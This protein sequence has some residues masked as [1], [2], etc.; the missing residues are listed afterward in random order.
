MALTPRYKNFTESISDFNRMLDGMNKFQPLEPQKQPAKPLEEA[1]PAVYQADADL[2]M[3]L[4]SVWHYMPHEIKTSIRYMFTE[5]QR[6]ADIYD[7]L[8]GG[9]IHFTEADREAMDRSHKNAAAKY[10]AMAEGY[11]GLATKA[12]SE[13]E[14]LEYS[15]L[16]DAA[17]RKS[18]LHEKKSG[19]YSGKRN[20]P[21]GVQGVDPA[22]LSLY[23]SNDSAVQSFRLL[24]GLDEKP[25]Q[26]RDPGMAG[27][28]RFNGSYFV[29][30]D[31]EDEKEKSKKK[32]KKKDKDD[33]DKDG[34]DNDECREDRMEAIRRRMRVGK[35][36]EYAEGRTKGQQGD[37]EFA[38][39]RKIPSGKMPGGEGLGPMSRTQRAIKAT[40]KHGGDSAKAS[41]RVQYRRA[42]QAQKGDPLAKREPGEAAYRMKG[43]L[44]K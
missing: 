2:R 23:R 42:A 11:G 22:F 4:D 28:T 39:Q 16:H 33:D 19:D 26:P 20:L 41:A 15:K 24:A 29:E 35:D 13:S 10:L 9:R 12:H 38:T 18:R 3:M 32:G 5:E 6:L 27:T 14:R 31:D 17:L 40:F 37:A 44:P 21:E 1:A 34:C 36:P 7:K 30:D 8:S 43:W 25:M